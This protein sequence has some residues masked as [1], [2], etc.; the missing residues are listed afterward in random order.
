MEQTDIRQIFIESAVR[1]VAREGLAKATTKAIA[2]EAKLNEAYIYKC[3]ASKDELL[4]A[5][6][7]QEDEGFARLL[8][9]ALPVMRLPG[10]TWKERAFLLWRKS[11]LFVLQNEDDGRFYLRYYYSADCR[12]YA[13]EDHLQCFRVLIDRVK[14]SFLPETDV[15]MLVHQIFDTMLAFAARVIDGEMPNDEAT[16]QRTFE[17]IYAFV[18][19]HVRPELLEE[20][21]TNG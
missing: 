3:F 14:P 6:F 7:R 5:A 18:A 19:P 9:E 1:V 12:K 10:F 16:T 4:S 11:W 2:A 15:N 8:H 20:E 17:Q 21:G 13:Y